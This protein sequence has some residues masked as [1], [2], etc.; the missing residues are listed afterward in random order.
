MLAR[1]STLIDHYVVIAA[2]D[3]P[4]VRV[5]EGCQVLGLVADGRLV[6]AGLAEMG[7]EAGEQV[8]LAQVDGLG[9]AAAAGL[10]LMC[11]CRHR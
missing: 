1:M 8:I 10:V 3:R 7:A 6:T 2:S 5:Q 11:P 4:L 9:R